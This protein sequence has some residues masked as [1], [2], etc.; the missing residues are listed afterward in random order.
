MRI[1][2]D[3]S[4]TIRDQPNTEPTPNGPDTEAQIGTHHEPA[5]TDTG[6]GFTT[7][8]NTPRWDDE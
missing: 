2:L 1:R 5:H 7:P 4:I 3:L 6:M 8:A